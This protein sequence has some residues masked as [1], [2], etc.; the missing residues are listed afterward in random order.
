MYNYVK[1]LIF[2]LIVA[3]NFVPAGMI[4]AKPGN[5]PQ[6]S[7]G[8]GIDLARVSIGGIKY[9]M[10]ERSV[11]RKLGNP[12]HRAIKSNCLG[13]IDRLHYPGLVVDLDQQKYVTWIAATDPRYGTDRGVKVGDSIEKAVKV[14][15]PMAHLSSNNTITIRDRKYGDLFI[16]FESNNRHRVTRISIVFEC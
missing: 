9:K 10:S 7:S 15:A 3:N 4:S 8:E 11:L 5:R 12:R 13:S 1:L 6:I 2:L 16:V 14:Y